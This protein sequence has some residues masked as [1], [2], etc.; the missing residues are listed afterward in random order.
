MTQTESTHI[1]S[2]VSTLILVTGPQVRHDDQRPLCP[3]ERVRPVKSDTKKKEES[4][5]S[6]ID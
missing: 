2:L 3:S 5:L 6:D 4:L 1:T